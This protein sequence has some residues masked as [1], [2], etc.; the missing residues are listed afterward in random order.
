M[1]FVQQTVNYAQQYS[2]ELANAYPYLNY[3]GEIYASAN[4]TKY[5]PVS[6]NTVMVPSMEVSGATA[7]NRNSINGAFSRNWNNAYEPKQ[8]S[9]YREWNTIIDPMD[10]VETNDVATIANVTKT[11]NELQKMP[12]MSAYCAQK[13]AGYAVAASNADT[14][15]L[16]S[17]NILTT[18]DSYLADMAD[19][20]VNRDR[21]ICYVTPQVYKLLKEATGLTRFIEV[22]NG[23][24]NVDRNIA[25]LDGVV[26]KEV[27]SDLMKS[28]YDFTEGF[29]ATASAKQVNMILVDPDATIAPIVYDVSMITPPSAAT[30]GKYV[31][32]ESFY[33]DV[34]NLRKRTKGIKV[35][36]EA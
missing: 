22:T 33:Y 35:N 11:F 14:T 7:V 20:R 2:K 21:L 1:A 12:E 19:A 36:I 10:I 31:Y 4:S 16:S 25:K 5:R 9:M 28:A 23:I 24:R 26:V 34:F 3:F 17:A 18:W 8:M 13:L 30:K 15:V 27:P 29:V 6:G 32:Y